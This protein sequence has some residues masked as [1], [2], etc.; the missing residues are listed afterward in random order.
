[1][2]Y[3][4][5]GS[6]MSRAR[7]CQRVPSAMRVAVASLRAHRVHFHKIGMGDGSGKC[8]AEYTGDPQDRIWGVVYRLAPQH[9]ATLDRFEGEGI[10]YRRVA[11]DVLLDTGET[12]RCFTYLA[13]RVDESLLPFTWYKR[14]VLIGARENGLPADYVSKLQAAKD[15]HDRNR[16]RHRLEM[17]LYA[18]SS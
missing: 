18:N 14:H 17:T 1:M 2:Y 6:N 10:G 16:E 3:F 9:R 11:V 7:L 12:C 13:T 8:G 5:Y 15:C 4:A